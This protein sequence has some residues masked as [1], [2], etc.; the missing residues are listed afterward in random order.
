MEE[1]GGNDWIQN[2]PSNIMFDQT[3]RNFIQNFQF[4]S[5]QDHLY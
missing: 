4:S 3:L 5:K 1:Q 2:K